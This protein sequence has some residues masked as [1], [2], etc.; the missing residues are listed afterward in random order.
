MSPRQAS[1]DRIESRALFTELPVREGRVVPDVKQDVLQLALV[2][3]YVRA[4]P[5]LSFIKGF[6]LKRGAMATTVAHD[7]HHLLAVG[8]S[9]EDMATAIN[10]VSRSGGYAVVDG[11]RLEQLPLD[12]AGLMSTSH[13]SIIASKENELLDMLKGMGCKLSAPFMTLSFQS[14]LVVPE[15]KISDRG[16]FD[17]VRM[18]IVSPLI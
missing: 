2:N 17:T 8:T 12:V 7:S 1:R 18:E 10:A 11:E 4:E 3:R 5:V 16:L 9:P 15:L 6:G 13:V 14:L